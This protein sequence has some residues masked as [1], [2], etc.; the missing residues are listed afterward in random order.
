MQVPASEENKMTATS[1]LALSSFIKNP[2]KFVSSV[3]RLKPDGS[4]VDDWSKGL[5]IVFMYLFNKASF[6]EDPNNFEVN[7]EIKGALRFFI[8]QTISV[9]LSEMI[10]QEVSPRLAFTCLKSHFLKGA[11]STQLE[12]LTELFEMY[13]AT[14]TPT[15]KNYIRITS[16]FERLRRTGIAIPRELQQL[17][18]N[19]LIP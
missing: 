18:T 12:L 7:D 17:I 9:E 13:K 16:I 6:T 8:Q 15:L 3:P 10:Q 5:D 1:T 4:N 2:L 19:L 11:R 14:T